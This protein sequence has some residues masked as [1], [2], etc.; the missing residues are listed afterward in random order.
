MNTV[1]ALG[2][3]P[4]L[5]GFALVGVRVVE[6][7]SPDEVLAAWGALGDDVG[8]VILTPAARAVISPLLDRRPTVLTVEL[9]AEVR[10]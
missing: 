5:R 4:V 3:S 9:P 6:T 10:A 8:L 1:V 7:A 2:E